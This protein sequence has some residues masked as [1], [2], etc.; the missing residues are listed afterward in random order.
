MNT[1][2]VLYAEDEFSNRE[3]LRI[4]FENAGLHADIVCNGTEAVDLCRKRQYDAVLLDHYMGE[5]DGIQ[6]AR[7]IRGIDPLIPLIAITSDDSLKNEMRE[8]GFNHIIIKPLRGN[9]VVTLL[10]EICNK[11]R[12]A[13]GSP[14]K[15]G[16]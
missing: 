7:M 9:T 16:D 5:P 1:I 8:A 2:S 14:F 12:A 10:A 3:L 15:A 6:T 4:K 13:S 11:K